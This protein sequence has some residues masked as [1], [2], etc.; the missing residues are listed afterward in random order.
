MRLLTAL[1]LYVV[2]FFLNQWQHFDEAAITNSDYTEKKIKPKEGLQKQIMLK[3][4]SPATSV[5]ECCC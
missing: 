1:N 4:L 3:S 5:M 2:F